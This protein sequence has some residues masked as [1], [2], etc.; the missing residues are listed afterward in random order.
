MDLSKGLKMGPVLS[1]PSPE[2]SSAFSQGLESRAA[3]T[4]ALNLLP[5]LTLQL[6]SSEELDV[7]KQGITDTAGTDTAAI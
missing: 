5:A 1:L 4:S 7:V 3:V 6:S 2:R